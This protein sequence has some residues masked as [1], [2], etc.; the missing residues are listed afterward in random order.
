M[1]HLFL[2]ALIPSHSIRQILTIFF[3]SWRLKDCIKVQEKNKKVVVLC[4]RPTQNV[5][6]GIFIGCVA[7][8]SIW[9][10][11]GAKKDREPLPTLL[12]APFFDFSGG[13]WLSFLVPCSYT[14][15]KRLLRK[16][17][18]LRGNRQWRQRNVQKSVL[19]VQSSCF[20]NLILLTF[21]RFRCRR[22]RQIGS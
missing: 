7:S 17:A 18:F 1:F 4:S 10:G 9:S 19:H 16:L 8:V 5:K 3:F 15:R 11:F 12:L 14:A 21:C 6:L 13:L 2:I 20:A 22:C